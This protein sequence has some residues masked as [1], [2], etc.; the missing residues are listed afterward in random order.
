MDKG[1]M[2]SYLTLITNNCD[3]KM[4]GMYEIFCNL[5]RELNSVSSVQ[6]FFHK[7]PVIDGYVKKL[8]Y[9]CECNPEYSQKS[10]QLE[11]FLEFSLRP[12]YTKVSIQNEDVSFAKSVTQW[13][14]INDKLDVDFDQ[15][16]VWS[17]L[18]TNF[19]L[20]PDK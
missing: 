8:T 5:L 13:F 9:M 7:N 19:L 15:N 2:M 18:L 3:E 12:L 20:R 11:N 16:I 6:E 4:Q 10:E 1:E 17:F 14:T